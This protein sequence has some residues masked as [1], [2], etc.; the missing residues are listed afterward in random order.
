MTQHS[1]ELVLDFSFNQP[2]PLTAEEHDQATKIVDEVLTAYARAF[3]QR[4]AFSSRPRPYKRHDLIRL[5]HEHA[6]PPYG[7]DHFVRF[8]LAWL[9][10]DSNAP[11]QPPPAIGP[12]LAQLNGLMGWESVLQETTLRRVETFGDY[13]VDRFFMP[14][15]ASGGSTP[16]PSPLSLASSVET[17]VGTPGRLR[18]LRAACLKRD[19]H[20]CVLSR[21]FDTQE[22]YDRTEARGREATDDDG[23]LLEPFQ[24]IPEVLEVAH[25]IPHAFT[26]R[27]SGESQV[28]EEKMQTL[29]IL[30]MFDPGVLMELDGTNIDR[31]YNA[32]TLSALAHKY[33]GQLK[34]YFE[35]VDD[36]TSTASSPT[37]HHY[38][39]KAVNPERSMFQV[40]GLPVRRTLLEAHERNIDMPSPRLLRIHR[41]CCL[42]AHLSG[43]GAY[44]ER[45]LRDRD[46]P[47]VEADGSTS[48]GELVA[49]RTWEVGA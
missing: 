47:R 48:L 31:P 38:S 26:A 4:G 35:T 46:A 37:P 17:A 5:V 6:V 20:R 24:I 2:L 36:G 16:L 8:F 39:I 13:L 40:M 34:I 43:A 33:F 11:P 1:R 49:L 10:A 18:G 19:H 41:A 30:N 7:P 25:I 23:N 3:D 22:A 27:S 9:T 12:T 45:I 44:I 14:F 21:A 15:R 29:A 42:V 32:L 28:N